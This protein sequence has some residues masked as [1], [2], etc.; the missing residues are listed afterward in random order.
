MFDDQNKKNEQSNFSL[1]LF[2]RLQEFYT[3][4]KTQ[5]GIFCKV[6][7]NRLNPTDSLNTAILENPWMINDTMAF[8]TQNKNNDE[9]FDQSLEALF[10]RIPIYISAEKKHFNTFGVL[11]ENESFN[12]NR[13]LHCVVIGT[14]ALLKQNNDD[15]FT[16]NGKCISSYVSGINFEGEESSWVKE[17]ADLVKEEVL[18]NKL[19]NVYKIKDNSK[20]LIRNEIDKI[21]MCSLAATEGYMKKHN[22]ENVAKYFLA[23]GCG[24]FLRVL[25]DESK[26][27]M[28][29]AYA[30]GLKK[31]AFLGKKNGVSAYLCLLNDFELISPFYSQCE[32]VTV[33]KNTS[34]FVPLGSEDCYFPSNR[35]FD[36]NNYWVNSNHQVMEIVNA[37]DS[38]SFI[39]NGQAQDP[40]VDGWYVSNWGKLNSA[41]YNSSFLFNMIFFDSALH[42]NIYLVNTDK[43]V[44]F[45]EEEKN[46]IKIEKI[47][48][49]KDLIDEKKIKEFLAKNQEN[50]TEK[51]MMRETYEEFS[52]NQHKMIMN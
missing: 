14:A 35:F 34:L 52:L 21:F 5:N 38:L 20:E 15:D 12:K 4:T 39:G 16:I 18:G 23:I 33:L 43:I 10:T 8:L 19:R 1:K 25:D 28:I 26:K 27:F 32:A 44:D 30:Y 22:I 47:F 7:N 45:K 11:N 13:I 29:E 9:N 36:E 6:Y 49:D 24:A 17:H 51:S 41:F 31:A 48:M 37:W 42:K 46:Y 50:Y 3:S 2:A 40:S